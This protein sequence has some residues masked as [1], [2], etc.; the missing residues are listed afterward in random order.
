MPGKPYSKAELKEEQMEK[1]AKAGFAKSN[2]K[3]S[4]KAALRHKIV[5]MYSKMKGY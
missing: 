2:P 5:S 3:G 4:A 1:K